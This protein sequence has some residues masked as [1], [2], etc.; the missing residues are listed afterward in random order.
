[1]A[2]ELGSI[3]EI[4]SSITHHQQLL[5]TSSRSGSLRL[6]SP[7]D[8][9]CATKYLCHLRDQPHARPKVTVSLVVVSS[10]IRQWVPDQPLSRVIECWRLAREHKPDLRR[11]RDALVSSLACRY[12]L[13][14]VNDDYKEAASVLDKVITSSSAGDSQDKP[15]ASVQRP[16]TMLATAESI[17]H[18]TPI[19][20]RQYIS[21]I[22]SRPTDSLLVRDSGKTFI[23][24]AV[25]VL[26]AV[27]N[28]MSLLQT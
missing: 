11:A 16:V 15:A 12:L 18:G 9:I 13:T 27:P 10:K 25:A 2:D 8:A 20:R 4:D 7:Q 26:R 3:R 28:E 24:R 17:A 23:L 1:M 21:C 5:A 6:L 19:Q 22:L 14:S